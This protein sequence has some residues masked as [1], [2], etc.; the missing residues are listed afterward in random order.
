MKLLLASVLLA[1]FGLTAFAQNEQSPIVEKDISYKDWSLKSVRDDKEVD[2]RS[3]AQGKKLVIVVYFAPWC[4]NWK[5]DAEFLPALYDK[6]K[7]NGLEMVGVSE[8]GTVDAVKTGLDALKVTFPVVYESIDRADKQKTKH[9]DYRKETGDTRNWGS[10]WYI[11]LEPAKFE[12]KGDT[13]VKHT[14][15]INGEM[16]RT[17]GE[18]FI[19]EHLGLPALDTTASAVSSDP[20]KRVEPCDPAKPT[21]LKKP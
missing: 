17:E 5:H 9:Y 15:V 10:P 7:A 12:Q 2:L 4:P 14:S 18:R 20:T 19:R 13:L 1:I 16:I 11:F 3:L 21:E 6:Y 8:Y